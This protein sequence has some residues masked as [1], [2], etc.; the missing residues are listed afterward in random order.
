V[1]AVCTNR[2]YQ[3]KQR[4]LKNVKLRGLD[5]ADTD[6]IFDGRPLV[7][8]PSRRNNEDRF[9][10]T[11]QIEGKLLY[12]PVDVARRKPVDHFIQEG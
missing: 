9:V 8:A 7:T 3:A 11:A 12:G 4:R 5:F 1:I 2:L 10:S 6:F